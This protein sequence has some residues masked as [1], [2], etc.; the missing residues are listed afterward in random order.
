MAK[1]E[2]QKLKLIYILKILM[3]KTDEEHPMTLLTLLEELQRYEIT[4]ERKSI[5]TD[6]EN[7]RRFGVDVIKIKK[8]RT[9]YYYIGKRPFELP[10]LKLLVDSVQAAKFITKK[11]TDELIKKIEGLASKYE[12]TQLQR[13]VYVAE[14]V[15]TMNESIYYSVDRIH[16]AISDNSRI[17]FQYFQWNR[18]KEMVL[19]W[20]GSFYDVSPWALSWNDGNYYMVAYDT[21]EKMIK[22]FRVDKMIHIEATGEKRLGKEVFKKFDMAVYDKKMFGMFGGT[23]ATV[24]L[25]CENALA[26]VILD[27]FGK[28]VNLIPVG[29][30]CFTVNVE[31]AVSRQFVFWVL[32]LGDGAKIIAP[33]AVVQLVKSEIDRLKMQYLEQDAE[34]KG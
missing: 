18:K 11:K 34:A 7:L 6:F 15:K 19:R 17:K 31:V 20:D 4:A 23:E 33:D 28:D 14:R 24:K 26:G 25:L 5:Y 30:D 8:N 10:E 29:D 1:S 2:N 32:G 9:S 13:Q 12:A 3:E 22:H 16:T 27:R 21:H